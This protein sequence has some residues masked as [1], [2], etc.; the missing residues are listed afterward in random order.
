MYISPG[1]FV[2]RVSKT[3]SLEDLSKTYPDLDGLLAD[4]TQVQRNPVLFPISLIASESTA[5][6]SLK[7][8]STT[9]HCMNSV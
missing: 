3:L 5:Q 1:S 4:W 9:F 7:I 8:L 2:S 6:F